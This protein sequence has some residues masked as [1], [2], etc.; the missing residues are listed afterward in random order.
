MA[1][2]SQ[3][4]FFNYIFLC[5]NYCILIEISVIYVPNCPINTKPALIQV[6]AWW[7]IND[8]PLS[9]PM[10]ALF[11]DTY[12]QQFWILRCCMEGKYVED[13]VIKLPG[14]RVMNNSH[15]LIEKVCQ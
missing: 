2:I 7:Q 8:K 15:K 9:D 11:T 10:M 13:I 3:T 4:S 14:L 5:E 12:L 6:M 1:G